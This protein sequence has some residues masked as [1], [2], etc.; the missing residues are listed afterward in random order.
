MPV[1][2]EEKYAKLIETLFDRT[3][4]RSQSWRLSGSAVTTDLGTY[5]VSISQEDSFGSE[6]DM[7]CEIADEF[8][9]VVDRFT[10]VELKDISPDVP[11]YQSFY[12]LMRALYDRAHREASGA[13]RVL[14]SILETLNA[15]PESKPRKRKN[16]DDDIPF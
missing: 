11:G 13:E 16:P 2:T 7:V 9:I 10:D 15:I 12:L 4:E 5:T 8:G 14:D 3:F 6:V 1:S